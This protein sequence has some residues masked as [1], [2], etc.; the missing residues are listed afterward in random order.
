M[1]SRSARLAATAAAVAILGTLAAAA[2]AVAA[3]ADNAAPVAPASAQQ[4]AAM[5]FVAWYPNK[6]QCENGGAYYLRHG[7]SGYVC[8]LD[9]LR[10]WALYV[11]D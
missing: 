8:Q 2:P 11:E 4:I 5:E 9:P 10:G 1:R 7:Y 6:T 3:P